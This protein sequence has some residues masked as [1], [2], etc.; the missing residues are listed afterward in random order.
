MITAIHEHFDNKTISISTTE[1]HAIE[2]MTWLSSVLPLFPYRPI[3]IDDS[4]NRPSGSS[5][6][7]HSVKSGKYSKVF[8]PATDTDSTSDSTFDPSTIASS[9]PSRQNAWNNGPPI[10]VT[11]DRRPSP[12]SVTVN[13]TP[14]TRTY[15]GTSASKASQP[16]D[17]PED[18]SDAT[19]LTRPS[20]AP[21]DIAEL[22]EKAL[23]TE[24][25]E[26]NKR[27]AIIEQ[28]QKD[29]QEKTK[30]WEQKLTDMRKQIVDATVTGTISVLTGQSSPFA[31]KDDAQKQRMENATEFQS[32]K[33]GMAS[34]QTALDILQQ[35]MTIMLQRTEQL[36][37]ERY[38]PSVDSPPRKARATKEPLPADSP[39][40]DVE[41]VGEG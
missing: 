2:V 26:M 19:P 25:A 40:T 23:A 32:L 20:A 9:R 7:G 4:N 5:K 24:R 3:A 1:H 29:F 11:F 8:T 10:N 27:L 18:S 35:N 21:S 33:E 36:F 17:D 28:Q 31:T 34:N 41:G 37:A 22:V 15:Y 39:M 14:P 6:G 16:Y 30:T 12:R 38:D 13:P